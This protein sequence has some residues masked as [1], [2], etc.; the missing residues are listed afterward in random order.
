VYWRIFV[1]I[2]PAMIVCIAIVVVFGIIISVAFPAQPW[3]I[4][5]AVILGYIPL[6]K[7]GIH[8][9]FITTHALWYDDYTIEGTKVSETATRGMFWSILGNYAFVFLIPMLLSS[10]IG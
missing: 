5:F 8:I 2:I 7:R 3:A 6:I 9:L 4:V 10:I 1:E